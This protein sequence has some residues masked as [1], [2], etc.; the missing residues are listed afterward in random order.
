YDCSVKIPVNTDVGGPGVVTSFLVIAAF[1]I[2]LAFFQALEVFIKWQ[3]SAVKDGKQWYTSRRNREKGIVTLL[4]PLCDLQ[5]VTG[6]A[7]IVAGMGQWHSIDFYHEQLVN[8]YYALT[9]N[10]FWATRPSYMDVE[11]NEDAWVLFLRRA[12]VL[13]SCIL[14]IIWQFRLYFRETASGVWDDDTGPCFRYLDRSNA[15]FSTIFWT[16]GLT[17]I[18]LV[19]EV[20]ASGFAVVVYFLFLQ[21]LDVWSYGDGFYPLTWLAYLGFYAWNALD[22]ISMVLLNRNLLQD[23]EWAW[24][25]GQVL[26]MVVT[27]S[28]LFL[29]V[30]VFR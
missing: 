22:V 19:I 5:I 10:S 4:R 28:V 16:T 13:V 21:L 27:L 11:S 18:L 3:G 23:E 29:I 6:L 30:D 9:L 8:A 17:V 14:N 15:L 20:L 2:F 7:I 24:G 25:F 12:A 1:T 26:P